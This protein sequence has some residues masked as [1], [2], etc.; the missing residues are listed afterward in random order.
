MEKEQKEFYI[1][2]IMKKT[3]LS[4]EEIEQKV[5][6]KKN[7]KLGVFISEEVAYFFVVEDLGLDIKY[8]PKQK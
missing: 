3:E 7:G 1:S 5:D 8:K 4:R 6:E 2:E